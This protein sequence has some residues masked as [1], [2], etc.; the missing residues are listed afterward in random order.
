MRSLLAFFALAVSAGV[1]A[2]VSPAGEPACIAEYCAGNFP[3]AVQPPAPT[4]SVPSPL[5]AL[6]NAERLVRGMPLKAPVR[7]RSDFVRR[8][9]PSSVPVIQVVKTVTK[10][11]VIEVKNST[12]DCLGYIS[13]N[14]LSKAQLQYE[15]AI[16]NATTVTFPIQESSISASQVRITMEDSDEIGFPLL[17]LVQGANDTSVDIGSESYNQDLARGISSRFVTAVAGAVPA[18][19]SNAYTNVTT[20]VRAAESDV[21]TID[22]TTGNL[23]PQW[24]NSNGCK[25]GAHPHIFQALNVSLLA[26]PTTVLFAQS[27]ALYAGGNSSTFSAQFPSPITEYT[28]QFVETK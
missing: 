25:L 4:P 12:G 26:A 2:L 21:W 11:G 9:T 18:N 14:S 23:S 13:K 24:I 19:I 15:S 8:S 28:L 6:T 17:G 27:S 1:S 3:N 20:L 22:L 7:R 5:D 16:E 10:R